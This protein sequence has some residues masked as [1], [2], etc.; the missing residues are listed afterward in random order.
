MSLLSNES[1]AYARLWCSLLKSTCLD[2][3][4]INK[5]YWID[6]LTKFKLIDEVGEKNTDPILNMRRRGIPP[7]ES[8]KNSNT[9]DLENS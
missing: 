5:L 6:T 1:V 4:P 9:N 2:C 3:I 8:T 7:K